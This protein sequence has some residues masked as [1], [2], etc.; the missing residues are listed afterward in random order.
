MRLGNKCKKNFLN[1][2]QSATESNKLLKVNATL[3]LSGRDNAAHVL[4]SHVKTISLRPVIKQQ[5]TVEKGR[6]IFYDTSRDK[7]LPCLFTCY[8]IMCDVFLFHSLD[9]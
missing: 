2:L 3:T 4:R 8:C 6:F 1:E 7:F 9:G 5:A